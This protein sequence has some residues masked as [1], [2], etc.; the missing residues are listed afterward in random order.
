VAD[1]E[2]SSETEPDWTLSGR[3]REVAAGWALALDEDP[4]NKTA[5]A[6]VDLLDAIGDAVDTND[7]WLFEI[8]T[9]AHHRLGRHQARRQAVR[10]L[11]E[12]FEI[13]PSS[14]PYAIGDQRRSLLENGREFHDWEGSVIERWAKEFLTR[15]SLSPLSELVPTAFLN[16][17]WDTE[18]DPPSSG[19]NIPPPPLGAWDPTPDALEKVRAALMQAF[20]VEDRKRRSANSLLKACLRA[21]GTDERLLHNLG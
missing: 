19:R 10:E 6:M 11:R 15:L 3:L 8:A 12:C 2:D 21:L 16:D 5:R 18:S 17:E 4:N 7:P 20:G 1:D 9:D 14:S 13:P